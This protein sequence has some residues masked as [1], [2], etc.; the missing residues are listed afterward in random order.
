MD[1]PYNDHTCILHD[2]RVNTELDGSYL[3]FE[4]LLTECSLLFNDE[5]TACKQS[6]RESSLPA[7]QS[8]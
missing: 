3:W 1:H 5:W 6:F 8:G 2:R 7:W 4:S